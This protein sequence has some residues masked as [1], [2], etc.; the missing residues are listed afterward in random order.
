M[1]TIASFLVHSLAVFAG[2]RFAD[3][4]KANFLRAMVVALLSYLAMG[5]V[6]L[7]MFPF[8]MFAGILVLFLGTSI[9]AR[10][11]LGC[12]WGK[13]LAVGIVAAVVGTIAHWLLRPFGIG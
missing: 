6:W 12:S 2:A 4:E 5:L 9:A 11:V 1:G 3:I 8:S 10:F 7:L 13:A